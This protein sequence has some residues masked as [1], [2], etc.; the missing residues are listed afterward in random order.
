MIVKSIIKSRLRLSGMPIAN[1]D[2][3]SSTGL[4]VEAME[5]LPT[6]MENKR[7]PEA[8]GSGAGNQQRRNTGAVPKS[9]RRP[10]RQYEDNRR[11]WRSSAGANWRNREDHRNSELTEPQKENVDDGNRESSERKFYRNNY[12]DGKD[13]FRR[14]NN[15]HNH[16]KNP[17][18]S[19]KTNEAQISQRERL[20]K[21][22]ESNTLECMICCEK[23]KPFQPIFGC[24]NCYSLL[25]L[26]CIKTWV[27]NSK[28]DQGE[29]RCPA[30]NQ[31]SKHKPSEYMCFCGKL[32]NPAV[33]RNDLA[34]SC[35]DMCLSTSTC[36]HPCQLRCH[37]GN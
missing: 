8:T 10:N 18:S 24:K 16:Q 5:F 19:K 29:W 1:S 30:C 14:P 2:S 17:R 26:N 33:N 12:R 7:D 21:D 3:S 22:I 37:P 34:H 11:N 28:T 20:T 27:K 31:V 4:N 35:G 32:K 9:Q 23:I 15:N 25:H 6:F 36:P 13:R